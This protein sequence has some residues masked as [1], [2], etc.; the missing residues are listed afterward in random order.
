MPLLLSS[1]L[2]LWQ[3]LNRDDYATSIYIV[4]LE[5]IRLTDFVGDTREFITTATRLSSQ[6]YP[7][8][9]G[10]I[11]IINVP[12]WFKVIWQ[13]VRPMVAESTLQ[14][15]HI[16]RG[17]DEIQQSLVQ[18]IPLENIPREY[19]GTS[20]I[21]LGHSPE[22]RLLADLMT[23]NNMLASERRA[24]CKGC[25]LN[26]HPMNWPCYFCRWTPARSY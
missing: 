19:G 22:E 5:G 6:H 15:I 9:G 1:F 23:H 11:F 21:P 8:R 10:K 18:Q 7:E 3:F 13:V 20:V 2:V 16:L 17:K 4:D 24:T 25:T 12:L 14:K 26:V